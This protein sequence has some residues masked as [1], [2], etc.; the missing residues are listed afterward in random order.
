MPV[1][2]DF[3]N[4]I[5]PRY[6]HLIEQIKQ[7]VEGSERQFYQ[8][9]DRKQESGDSFLWEHTIHVATIA[10][11]IAEEE[12]V[13][14]LDVVIAVLFHDSGKFLGGTYH[15]DE[16][17]EEEKAAKLAA[18]VL[19]K[20]GMDKERIETIAS[21]LTALYN[22]SVQPS[23]IT[24]VVHDADFLA[25]FGYLGVA[26]FFTKSAL[27][28]KNLYK[29][30]IFSLSKELTYAAAL[31][32]NMRT[33]AGRKMAKKKSVASLDYFRGLLDELRETGI[34]SFKITEEVFPCPKNPDK[35]LTLW[36]ALPEFCPE[37]Q[38][39]LSMDFTSQAKIKCEELSADIRCVRCT[40]HYL[41]S[42][43]LPE[44]C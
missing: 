5:S 20:E 3:E 14:E 23:R 13:D 7:L 24:D 35:N 30:L 40:N 16:S 11:K 28:G 41:V 12:N 32:S 42:F 27:R 43:C 25:K 21:S 4:L 18:E 26:S 29:T 44:I 38:G 8:D 31:E 1:K 34:A 10:R 17:P 39:E 19:T 36:M 33:E 37:C 15:T 2:K 9:G 22:D 6:P